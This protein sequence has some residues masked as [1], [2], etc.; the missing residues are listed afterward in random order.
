MITFYCH[1][2]DR[3]D[4]STRSQLTRLFNWVHRH[5]DIFMDHKL[6]V[7]F[8][9]FTLLY[10]LMQCRIH[11]LRCGGGGGGRKNRGGGGGAPPRAPPRGGGGGGGG[12]G[13]KIRGKGSG[14]LPWIRHWDG[15]VTASC[16]AHLSSQKNNRRASHPGEGE[17][18][19]SSSGRLDKGC[20]S[21]C[22]GL[23]NC[24][25]LSASTVILLHHNMFLCCRKNIYCLARM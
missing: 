8:G 6:W 16:S 18:L 9:P 5:V 2:P 13:V 21:S 1:F 12:G 4:S 22:F 14:P 15:G 10:E 3:K 25:V 19:Y 17:S 24:T 20:G 7:I 11:T 23:L